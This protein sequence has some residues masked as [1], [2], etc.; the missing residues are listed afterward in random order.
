MKVQG[1]YWA[2]VSSESATDTY[3]QIGV[4]FGPMES[5]G[6]YRIY[7][8]TGKNP[9]DND[10]QVEVFGYVNK[11]LAMVMKLADEKVDQ[12][13]KQS[14]KADK[15]E[16]LQKIVNNVL[17][18]YTIDYAY[19]KVLPMG[20]SNKVYAKAV[21]PSIP[22]S[23]EAFY[24]AWTKGGS[25]PANA[26]EWAKSKVYEYL[27]NSQTDEKLK[28][29]VRN[30]L[31]KVQPGH[32]YYLTCDAD[33]TFGF[34]E[35]A[36][37]NAG[38]W[39]LELQEATPEILK[40]GVY[41]IQNYATK[42]YVAVTDKYKAEPSV[43][44]SDIETADK[45]QTNITLGLGLTNNVAANKEGKITPAN[46]YEVYDLSA[47]GQSVISYVDKAVDIMKTVVV[48]TLLKKYPDQF[49]ALFKKYNISLTQDQ[50]LA[51]AKTFVDLYAG[52]YAKM[53]VLDNGDGTVSLYVKTPHVPAMADEIF[54]GL[55]KVNPKGLSIWEW[56]KKYT[57]DY[58]ADGHSKNI[59]VDFVKRNLDKITPGDK[60]YLA[61][62][63]QNTFDMLIDR[64]G[65]TPDGASFA[66]TDKAK[67]NLK[68]VIDENV[69]ENTDTIDGYFRIQSGAGYAN[70]E[71]Y[72]Q[73]TDALWAAPNQTAEQVKTE[74]G[75]V[76]YV[77]AV[78]VKG[79]N[80]Y[81]VINLRSQGIEVVGG[82][83]RFSW[84]ALKDSMDAHQGNYF[85]LVRRAINEGYVRWL[86]SL[87]ELGLYHVASYIDE[88]G[89]EDAKT[90]AALTEGFNQAVGEDMDLEMYMTPV[91][92]SDG[93]TKSYYLNLHT[94]KLDNVVAY[95]K[96]NQEA[97]N[98]GFKQMKKVL[99]D[100]GID[101][102]TEIDTDEQTT[103]GKLG[104]EI[105]KDPELT[106][107]E[108][109]KASNGNY[110]LSYEYIFAH[111][112]LLFY[113]L[114]LNIWKFMESD[115]YDSAIETISGI[116]QT[117]DIM[118]DLRWV[119][120]TGPGGNLFRRVH[121]DTDYYL[122]NGQLADDL[123]EGDK[124]DN[125]GIFGAANNNTDRSAFAPEIVSA[126]DGAKWVMKE[127]DDKDNYFGIKTNE[128][129]TG[130]SDGKFYTTTYLDFPIDVEKTQAANSDS[131][132]RFWNV[133]SGV[134]SRTMADGT[135]YKYVEVAEVADVVPAGLPV[136]FESKNVD[137]E[138]NKMIPAAHDATSTAKKSYLSGTF[139]NVG[140]SKYTTDTDADYYGKYI[141]D[142][143]NT[144]FGGTTDANANPDKFKKEL[145]NRYGIELGDDDSKRIYTLNKST[146]ADDHNPMGFY[147]YFKKDK[148]TG[149][150]TQWYPLSGNKAFMLV[151]HSTTGNAKVYLG[152]FDDTTGIS[153]IQTET[154][155][156]V[157]VLYDLQGRRVNTPHKGIYILNGKKILITK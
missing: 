70:D 77:K 7:S 47:N 128:K 97:F 118:A 148:T 53:K 75:S 4:G 73:V 85:P 11:A 36:A 84:K 149:N 62:D 61:A 83:E 17:T 96:A 42:H 6:A 19:M 79:T 15:S 108:T 44:E 40:S 2:D 14:H 60:I 152:G 140:Q 18:T 107:L 46:I 126:G 74:A 151:D 35:S 145:E 33:N 116:S 51:D 134:Q 139:F 137:A 23:I 95:V 81:K 26:W 48:D 71:N 113:W 55:Q 136:V 38:L 157:G 155:Q 127:V 143:L 105:A 142:G 67:W 63:D 25:Y 138:S 124:Y 119:Y 130:W 13:A 5:D 12:V 80:K 82:E 99:S 58:F 86:R 91:L 104:Y 65:K 56:A 49:Q 106:D 94:F 153:D 52:R 100:N 156:K 131:E 57:V 43:A 87:I 30:N 66:L 69:V 21:V 93:I 123:G 90:S 3:S 28:S 122:I 129:L 146:K 16:A 29:V 20:T 150:I 110:E 45:N 88:N 132:I 135:A 103:L 144:I 120:R 37:G 102:G 114:K 111:P 54:K 133:T 68:D 31:D 1:K 9:K 101:P 147:P 24:E 125:T 64:D 109:Y 98:T 72:V 78:P 76:I 10:A 92:L 27:N 34:S 112:Q 115:Q 121:W 50:L 89:G 117:K 32:T 154:G 8:L 59:D 39:E 141:Q 41:R 22:N